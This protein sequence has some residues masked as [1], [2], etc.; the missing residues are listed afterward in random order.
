MTLEPF[1]QHHLSVWKLFILSL[2]KSVSASSLF[3]TN[4]NKVVITP[5][6]ILPEQLAFPF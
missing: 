6:R 2:A 4:F 1:V 3:T 5:Q